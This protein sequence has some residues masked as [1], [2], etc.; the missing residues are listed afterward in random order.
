MAMPSTLPSPG[1]RLLAMRKVRTKQRQGRGQGRGQE[2]CYLVPQLLSPLQ[3]PLHGMQLL[4]QLL[5]AVL[6]LPPVMLQDVQ[7]D[8]L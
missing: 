4:A 5:P 6:G 2:G 8:A 1:A 3:L 7:E